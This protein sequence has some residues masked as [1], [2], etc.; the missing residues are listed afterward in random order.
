MQ[1]HLCDL[2][3][4][5]PAAVSIGPR[6]FEHLFQDERHVVKTKLAAQMMVYYCRRRRTQGDQCG[7]SRLG[8]RV[9]ACSS[10]VS[11]P[12]ALKR[13]RAGRNET[14]CI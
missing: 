8:T 10:G 7:T 6:T 9:P 4:R 1:R 14:P 5:Q 11:Y 13:G 3:T 12:M 2:F